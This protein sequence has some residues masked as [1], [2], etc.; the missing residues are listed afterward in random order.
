MTIPGVLSYSGSPVIVAQS[1]LHAPVGSWVMWLRSQQVASLFLA[2]EEVTMHSPITAKS[3][4]T[5]LAD[6]L[7]CLLV[8]IL[9]SLKPQRLADGQ[10]WHHSSVHEERK[11]PSLIVQE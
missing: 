8:L 4:Q 7:R 11:S 6:P 3:C 9:Q 5:V 2:V 10:Q 1:L